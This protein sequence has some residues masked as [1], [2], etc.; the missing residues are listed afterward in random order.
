MSN[1]PWYFLVDCV[2]GLTAVAAVLWSWPRLGT[3]WRAG[4]A[5]TAIIIMVL[6]TLNEYL[7]F[8]VFQA[9]ILSEEYNRLI[10]WNIA[11]T[12]VE[13]YIFWYSFAWMIPFLY[14]GLVERFGEADRRRGLVP[15]VNAHE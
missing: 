10:G 3:L 5:A 14:S 7:S 2:I 13:E 12:P 4:A 15:R 9:W 11:G 6:Q 8:H 1:W